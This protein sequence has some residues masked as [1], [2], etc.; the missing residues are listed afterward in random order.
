M[1]FTLSSYCKVSRKLA[2]RVL[3]ANCCQGRFYLFIIISER[4]IVIIDKGPLAKLDVERQPGFMTDKD[5]LAF[6]EISAE[7]G[8]ST[9]SAPGHPTD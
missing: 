4:V 6:S 8:A 9:C 5:S 3:Y 1:C 2:G 7:I